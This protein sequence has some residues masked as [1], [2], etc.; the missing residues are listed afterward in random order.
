MNLLEYLKKAKVERQMELRRMPCRELFELVNSLAVVRNGTYSFS[1]RFIL[2]V[3]LHD[4]RVELG[5]RCPEFEKKAIKI[6]KE[7][8]RK[9]IEEFE[10]A[11][12]AGILRW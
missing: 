7:R 10:A 9:L 6:A 1:R 3:A 8:E 4:A 12:R 11:H 2:N 5:N